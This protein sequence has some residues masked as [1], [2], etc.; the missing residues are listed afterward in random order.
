MDTRL[1]SGLR[2]T[3]CHLIIGHFMLNFWPRIL[4]CSISFFFFFI[5]SVCFNVHLSPIPMS[6]ATVHSGI[7]KAFFGS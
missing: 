1:A 7:T 2:R 3:L 6:C 5:I 4:L